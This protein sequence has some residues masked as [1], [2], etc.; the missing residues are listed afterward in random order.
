MKFLYS[1]KI[2]FNKSV[3]TLQ[4]MK[5]ACDLSANVCGTQNISP[6]VVTAIFPPK[7]LPCANSYCFTNIHT[8]T[9]SH[10]QCCVEYIILPVLP[11]KSAA[12]GLF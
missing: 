10:Y 1:G 6:D 5:S 2:F 3:P 7:V 12:K 4:L 9:D 8:P 11:P